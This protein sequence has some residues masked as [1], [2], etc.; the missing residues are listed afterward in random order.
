MPKNLN[1]SYAAVLQR[2][3]EVFI[4]QLGEGVRDANPFVQ[5]LRL[6]MMF[7]ASMRQVV[8]GLKE[9]YA[10]RFHPKVIA[11]QV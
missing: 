5:L 8:N 7:C 3:Y 11:Q 6:R 2:V 9:E 4:L 10:P 1:R